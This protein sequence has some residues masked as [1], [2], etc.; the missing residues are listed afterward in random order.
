[1]NIE[2]LRPFSLSPLA[3][4]FIQIQEGNLFATGNDVTSLVYRSSVVQLLVSCLEVSSLYLY[5]FIYILYCD[6]NLNMNNKQ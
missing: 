2:A 5:R 3:L 6:L 4:L 1:M